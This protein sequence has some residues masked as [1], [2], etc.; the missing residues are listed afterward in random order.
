MCIVYVYL[1]MCVCVYILILFVLGM[2]IPQ[3]LWYPPSPP[4]HYLLIRL[5][6]LN[7]ETIHT[8]F[9]K[10]EKGFLQRLS[11]IKKLPIEKF[12]I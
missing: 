3:I 4:L 7:T 5:Y 8:S 9:V 12:F 2:K 11:E 1:F 10:H 6:I